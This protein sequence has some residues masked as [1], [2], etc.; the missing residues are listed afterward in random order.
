MPEVRREISSWTLFKKFKIKV[1][2]H[3]LVTTIWTVLLTFILDIINNI[4][5]GEVK[6][7]GDC[8]PLLPTN[9]QKYFSSLTLNNFVFLGLILIFLFTFFVYFVNLWEEELRVRSDYYITNCLLDKFRRLPFE[10]K[11]EKSKEIDT[12]VRKDT[13]EVSYTWE[14]LPNHVYHCV[15]TITLILCLSW[16][17]FREMNTKGIIFSL[18]WLTLINVISFFFTRLVIRNEK[19]YKEELTKEWT[20]ISKES[21]KAGLIE[22]MGLTPRYRAKQ[23]E[24]SQKNE[25][26][27]LSFNLDKALNKT[28]PSHWLTEMFP[29]LLLFIVGRFSEARQNILPMWWIFGNFKEIFQCFWEYGE[30]SS[31]LTR[32]NNF[33]AL[34]EKNDN[35]QGI[36]LSEKTTIKA[37]NFESVSFKYKNSP[38]LILKNYTYSFSKGKINHLL[39]ENGIGKSTILFLILGILQPQQGKIS[40]ISESGEIYNLQNLNLKYWRENI[41]AYAS[42]DNL[43]EKGSTG[44]RQLTNLN[45]L[46][47]Q[48]SQAAIFLFDEADNALD[49][50]NQ[51]RFSQRLEELSKDKLVIYTKH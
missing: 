30:Y 41:V 25:N 10:E 22:S 38:E 39:G 35:L 31:S 16:E 2:K 40:I 9:L 6:I 49:K 7:N 4:I 12:L 27:L 15:L 20:V 44:Q 50:D 47:S 36:V 5:S 34:P 42:H 21:E 33:L 48:K 3:F 17:S 14:H 32:V 23:R 8:V 19:K 51:K 37:V 1:I 18:F 43:I 45:Q 11:Q 24:I 26:L 46:F 29:Y 28:I 13:G